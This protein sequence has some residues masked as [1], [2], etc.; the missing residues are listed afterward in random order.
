MADF[1]VLKELPSAPILKELPAAPILKELPSTPVL[2]ELP[3]VSPM[4]GKDIPTSA[5]LV[6]TGNIHNK[7]DLF[8]SGAAKAI[9]EPGGLFNVPGK[10]IGAGAEYLANK[11]SPGQQFVKAAPIESAVNTAM[12]GLGAKVPAEGAIRPPGATLPATSMAE[13]KTPPPGGSLGA[14]KAL[15]SAPVIK[16]LPSGAPPSPPTLLDHLES[17]LQEQARGVFTPEEI[18][19]VSVPAPTKDKPYTPPAGLELTHKARM[20]RATD[21][22]YDIDRTYFHGTSK[23]FE[24]WKDPKGFEK[25]VF[26]TEDPNIAAHYGGGGPGAGGQNIIPMLLKKG[27]TKTVDWSKETGY[28]HYTGSAMKNILDKARAEG[29]DTVVINNIKDLGSAGKPQTQI[30]VLSPVGRLRAKYGAAF[31]PAQTASGNMLSAAAVE[32]TP[33]PVERADVSKIDTEHYQSQGREHGRL[34]A[35]ND[36]LNKLTAEEKTPENKASMLAQAQGDPAHVPTPG[37]KALHEESIVPLQKKLWENFKRLKAM[38][39]KQGASEDEIDALTFDKNHLPRIPVRYARELELKLKDEDEGPLGGGKGSSATNPAELQQR[40]YFLR[41][42][43]DGARVVMRRRDNGDYVDAE[44]DFQGKK[45]VM[46]GTMGK[47]V[48]DTFTHMGK[49]YTVK[50]ATIREIEEATKGDET[51]EDYIKDPHVALHL[52]NL[53]IERAIDELEYTQNKRAE[54][55]EDGHATENPKIAKLK[56]YKETEASGF[57]GLYMEPRLKAA[58]DRWRAPKKD[59]GIEGIIAKNNFVTRTMFGIPIPHIINVGVGFIADLH[60]DSPGTLI[61]AWH[62]MDGKSGFYQ[63]AQEAGLSLWSSSKKAQAFY[64][65]SNKLVSELSGIEPPAKTVGQKAAAPFAKVWDASHQAM[66]YAQDVM[67]LSQTRSYMKGGTLRHPLG[68]ED[69]TQMAMKSVPSY[70]MPTETAHPGAG[71]VAAKVSRFP[72]AAAEHPLG[73]LLNNFSRYHYNLIQQAM[74]PFEA[75][76]RAGTAAKD[77][78]T[79]KGFK[80]RTYDTEAWKAQRALKQAVLLS[81][82]T[83]VVM[84]YMHEAYKK[85]T[86]DQR[87]EMTYHG[88]MAV[89]KA[90]WD[91]VH[92]KNGLRAAA[93]LSGVTPSPAAG[94]IKDV[95]EALSGDIHNTGKK[96]QA[97]GSTAETPKQLL[98]KLLMDVPIFEQADQ[99]WEALTKPGTAGQKAAKAVLPLTTGLAHTPYPTAPRANI[100]PPVRTR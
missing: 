69:A 78:A 7:Q 100:H 9:G 46:K 56:G 3:E 54:M 84:P 16:E 8:D 24:E 53:H 80:P 87:A 88:A 82:G 34:V 92:G 91:L 51:P 6:K 20:K 39:L 19:K 14:P 28:P 62:D 50:H 21:Q 75:V 52:G 23:D 41:E 2:A 99:V 36:E 1:P 38:M 76:F 26:L 95:G 45:V 44:P 83:A 98:G 57:K 32:K 71:E 58:L 22:G 89:Q 86:G 64:E 25:A 77:A 97:E 93:R 49:E 17:M 4:T 55:I 42:N 67:M 68:I 79:G 5:G 37:Q 63:K 70:R 27:K 10:A 73:R 43:A 35:A 85:L 59:S 65:A 13:V 81:F 47:K 48:G 11:V 72:S 31:D 94:A 90:M 33:H 74:K 66:K 40:R 15:P 61:Q 60:L 12:M 30:A 29:Y 96:A 18:N